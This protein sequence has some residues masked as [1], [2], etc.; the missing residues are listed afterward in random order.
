MQCLA[1]RDG[2]EYANMPANVSA[3]FCAEEDAGQLVFLDLGT[4]FLTLILDAVQVHGKVIPVPKV[5]RD[6][7]EFEK[8]VDELHAVAV[9]GMQVRV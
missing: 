6:D 7:P 3:C 4:L 9:K 8:H 2:D 1:F 5:S